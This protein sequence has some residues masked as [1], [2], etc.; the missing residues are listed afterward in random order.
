MLQL[1]YLDKYNGCPSLFLQQLNAQ[2]HMAGK[3]LLWMNDFIYA[4]NIKE[5]PIA[6]KIIKTPPLPI[7]FTEGLLEI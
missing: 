7:L 1:F 6:G 4:T 3:Q 5:K 2:Q